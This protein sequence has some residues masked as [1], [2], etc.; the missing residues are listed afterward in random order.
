MEL[1]N[2]PTTFISYFVTVPKRNFFAP[3]PLQQF[4]HYYK[5]LRHS[6]WH[7]YSHSYSFLYLNFSLIIQATTSRSSLKEPRLESRHLYAGHRIHNSQVA[8]MLILRNG[9]ALS[10]DV[11][12]GYRR[13]DSGSV[14]FVFLI[15]TCLSLNLTLYFNA[16][17]PHS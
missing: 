12:S 8:C 16:H 1:Q 2:N 3:L 10:F 6:S 5:L 13:V 15:Y 17:H 7:W 14:L 4:H 11:V 9:N